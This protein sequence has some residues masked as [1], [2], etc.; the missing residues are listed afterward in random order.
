MDDLG[1]DYLDRRNDLIEAV[2]L[3]DVRRVARKL[4]DPANLHFVVAGQPDGLKPGG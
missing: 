1:I 4:L 3:D 2:S